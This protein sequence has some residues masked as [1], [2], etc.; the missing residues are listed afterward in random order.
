MNPSYRILSNPAGIAV[1]G[2]L[3]FLSFPTLLAAEVSAEPSIGNLKNLPADAMALD[4]DLILARRQRDLLATLAEMA[5]L[6]GQI[7]PYRQPVMS[8][9]DESLAPD[10]RWRA[11]MASMP[12][13][14]SGRAEAQGLDQGHWQEVQQL[15]AEVE[16]LRAEIA[17]FIQTAPEM[18]NPP[19]LD[20]ES[21]DVPDVQETEWIP[22]RSAVRFVELAEDR[23]TATGEVE[24]P[25]V[26]LG[27]GETSARVEEGGTIR[28]AGRLV[29]LA[30]LRPLADGRISIGLEVDGTPRTILW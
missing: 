8:L 27:D 1:L 3:L 18:Y 24:R 26:W 13:G 12:S 29:R 9:L 23:E 20:E 16:S 25:A 2:G 17:L 5:G 30:V 22:D 21:G 10:D 28:F 4:R 7:Q 6:F 19:P 14:L 15:R 11:A